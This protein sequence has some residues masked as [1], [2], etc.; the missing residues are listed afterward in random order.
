L[1]QLTAND[2]HEEHLDKDETPQKPPNR[3]NKYNYNKYKKFL[4]DYTYQGNIY[5]I[6]IIA[7]SWDEA[8]ERL[9]SLRFNGRVIGEK[10]LEIPLGNWEKLSKTFSEVKSL[11]TKYTKT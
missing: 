2:T 3:I 4:C 6:E 11:L 10:F 5:S 7:E 9:K 8:E 1:Q